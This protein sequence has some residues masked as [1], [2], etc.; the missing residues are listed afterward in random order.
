L[1]SASEP[2]LIA[3]AKARDERAFAEIVRR[4]QS[5][6]RGLLLR[7]AGDSALADDL[8]QETFVRAWERLGDLQNPL[9]FAGW[10]R[11]IAV[12]AFLQAKRRGGGRVMQSLDAAEQFAAES[13]AVDRAAA[14]RIDLDRALAM[15]SPAERLCVT[16]NHGEG[17][18]HGEIAAL[19]GLPLGTV[20]SH[21]LRGVEKVRRAFGDE[22]A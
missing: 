6:M 22:D 5:W 3:A 10:L 21:I 2:A 15:L 8:A 9:A 13:P 20:K 14:S 4:R 12:T 19:T 18:S 17:L 7:L 11:R 1:G 16:L